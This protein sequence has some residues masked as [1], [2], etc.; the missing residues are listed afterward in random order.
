V[1]G[2]VTEDCRDK[3]VVRAIA[4]LRQRQRT[5]I[6][7]LSL[8]DPVCLS[9][10]QLLRLDVTLGSEPNYFSWSTIARRKGRRRQRVITAG[11]LVGLAGHL[12][13][14]LDRHSDESR[15]GLGRTRARNGVL[16]WPVT[17]TDFSFIAGGSLC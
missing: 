16:P 7:G 10:Q 11:R 2:E 12:L 17:K 4:L 8:G 6:E 13:R 15:A 1:N 5:A 9:Q 3:R 14:P